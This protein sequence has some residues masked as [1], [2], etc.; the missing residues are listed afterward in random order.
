MK[1]VFVVFALC[2]LS[3]CAG[4]ING[5]STTINISPSDKIETENVKVEMIS[6]SGV[7]NLTLPTVVTVKKANKPITITV[8]D[9]C[10]RETFYEVN[11]KLDP[12]F[13]GDVIGGLFIFVGGFISTT[14][15]AMSGALWT[16]DDAVIVPVISNGTCK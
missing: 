14:S 12:G 3:S 16:Y 6:K 9:K 13:A 8:K 11:R 1:K 7:Q 15:D 5:T 10:Y 4:M 2:L